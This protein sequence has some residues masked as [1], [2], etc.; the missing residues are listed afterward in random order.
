MNDEEQND[1]ACG[2]DTPAEADGS[3][4]ADDDAE[5]RDSTLIGQGFE[6]PSPSGDRSD[7]DDPESAADESPG[8]VPS[9]LS[10]RL[11]QLAADSQADPTPASDESASMPE[12]SDSPPLT[13][14]EPDVSE[15][16]DSEPDS[17]SGP[18]ADST[19]DS[20]SES[21]DSEPDDSELDSDSEES[22]DAPTDRLESM[23]FDIGDETDPQHGEGRA[24]DDAE[25]G[26]SSAG[27]QRSTHQMH[28]PVDAQSAEPEGDDFAVEPTVLTDTSAPHSQEDTDDDGPDT[29][30]DDFDVDP[31]MMIS[32]SDAGVDV[33]QGSSG[34]SPSGEFDGEKTQLSEPVFSSADDIVPDSPADSQTSP[35]PEFTGEKTEISDSIFS[36]EADDSDPEITSPQDSTSAQSDTPDQP[37]EFDAPKTEISPGFSPPDG[38]DSAPSDSD[39]QGPEPWVVED[40]DASSPPRA[41]S[42]DSDPDHSSDNPSPTSEIAR[43]E[44]S[45]SSSTSEQAP[46]DSTFE[47]GSTELFDSPFENDPICPRLTTL[48]GPAVGQDFFIDH[49]RNTVGR[50][51][52]NTVVVADRAMSRKHFE[53]IQNPDDTYQLHDL[54]AVNGTSL[55]GVDIKEADLFHGDRIA[56][57]QST[58]QFVIPGDAPVQSGE[59][60]LV[61]AASSETVTDQKLEAVEAPGDAGTDRDTL[62]TVL[63]AVTVIAGLLCIPLLAILIQATVLDDTPDEAA[64]DLY[65]EGVEALQSAQWDEAEQLFVRSRNADPEFGEIEAQLARVEREQQANAIIDRARRQAADGLDSELLSELRSLSPESHYY[66]D[67]QQLL[68]QA[69]QDE[70]LELYE[71]ALS[72]YEDDELQQ[73]V[74][75][76]DELRVVAPQYEPADDLQRD[77]EAALREDGERQ[78]DQQQAEP[79]RPSPAPEPQTAPQQP[80]PSSP[81]PASDDEPFPLGDPFAEREGRDDDSSEATTGIGHINFTD[82]FSMYRDEQFDDAIEHFETIADNAS[83]AV[84]NRAAQTAEDIQ[85][86]HSSLQEG[87]QARDDGDYETAIASFRT[88]RQADESVAGEGGSFQA[89]VGADMSAAIALQGR[90]HLE[91]E[92]YSAAFDRLERAEAHDASTPEVE[93][94][95]VDLQNRAQSLYIRAANQRKSDPEG[96]ANLARTI[97]T[98]VPP[99]HDTHNRARELLDELD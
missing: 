17:G 96:A 25:A 38:P 50:A 86:F 97:L 87:R 27:T 78:D 14:S 85:R 35:E 71:R 12:A 48:E 30:V 20:G 47:A 62:D 11:K 33:D 61:P 46:D 59:R 52:D 23:P 37:A 54:K 29:D 83:G 57:G 76:L 28:S 88:A 41:A 90:Q 18:D 60:H 32:E 21:D 95:R 79:A 66:D 45:P 8:V 19:S 74:A 9:S 22:A 24:G 13:D 68:S 10:K 34:E 58:F 15:P 42:G 16:D 94:L 80:P 39:A 7:E 53:I 2:G 98:M 56:A 93:A 70:A 40:T 64:S 43:A 36:A 3:P 89:D 49:S 31:T 5:T 73:A 72:A 1:S 63:L 77:I 75:A 67:A 91:S 84:G 69:H 26:I 44:S 6:L 55:N 82:G 51:T 92:D 4:A 81:E 99:D 65:F